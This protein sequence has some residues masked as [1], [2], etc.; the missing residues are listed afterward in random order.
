MIRVDNISKYL[1]WPSSFIET[2]VKNLRDICL[3]RETYNEKP[4]LDRVFGMVSRLCD[5]EDVYHVDIY[6]DKNNSEVFLRHLYNSME[7]TFCSY[8]KSNVII[9]DKT[10]FCFKDGYSNPSFDENFVVRENWDE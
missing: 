2:L 3:T 1:S 5:H 6:V 4:H 7:C 9:G 10:L 8:K